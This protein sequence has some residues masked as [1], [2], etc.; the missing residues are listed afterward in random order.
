MFRQPYNASSGVPRQLL[1]RSAVPSEV[2]YAELPSGDFGTE[3]LCDALPVISMQTIYRIRHRETA[4]EST[5]GSRALL[6]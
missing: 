2:G 1:L 6:R 4:V 5:G 3:Q